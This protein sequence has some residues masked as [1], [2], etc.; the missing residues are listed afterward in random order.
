[1]KK[2]ILGIVG[3]VMISLLGLIAC[4]KE[5]SSS[6]TNNDK[7]ENKLMIGDYLQDAGIYLT[8][9]TNMF[10]DCGLLY[11]CGRCPAICI[12]GGKR[13]RFAENYTA[14]LLE[15][16]EGAI[17]IKTINANFVVVEFLTDNLVYN[18][19]TYIED[20]FSLGEDVSNAYGF[21]DIILKEGAYDVS[22]VNAEYGIAEINVILN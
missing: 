21:Q 4:N 2:S 22:F 9:G 6:H 10:G 11:P 14:D 3:I 1:M 19:R 5:D 7:Y 16:G 18:G 13:P 12:K 20:D 8:S 15:Y 17:R